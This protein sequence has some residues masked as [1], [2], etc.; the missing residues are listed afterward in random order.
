MGYDVVGRSLLG[1]RRRVSCWWGGDGGQAEAVILLLS[2]C[3][4]RP[5]GEG[6]DTI[7][8]HQLRLRRRE[9]VQCGLHVLFDSEAEGARHVCLYAHAPG[10]KRRNLGGSLLGFPGVYE[11]RVLNL[12]L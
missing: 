12:P 1:L 6:E 9:L 8:R 10:G 2:Y 7:E 3:I 11:A 4:P 5:L